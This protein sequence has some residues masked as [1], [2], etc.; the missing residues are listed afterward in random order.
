[1][2]ENIQKYVSNIFNSNQ[3][4]NLWISTLN[5]KWN[6]GNIQPTENLINHSK[7]QQ[8]LARGTKIYYNQIN[9]AGL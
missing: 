3:M 6:H 5:L 9:S 8:Q 4:V 2:I 7:K 1:M